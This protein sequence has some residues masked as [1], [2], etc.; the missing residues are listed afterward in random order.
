MDLRKLDALV[1]EHVMGLDVSCKEI[2][3]DNSTI[4]VKEPN[5]EPI[6]QPPEM[7][8]VYTYKTRKFHPESYDMVPNYST[9]ISNA[10]EVKERISKLKL[11]N[12]FI[13]HLHSFTARQADLQKNTDIWEKITPL[14]I[15]IAAL[16]AIDKDID[17]S[18]WDLEISKDKGSG[19]WYGDRE[20]EE[21]QTE[22]DGEDK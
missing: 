11:W 13:E 6:K 22:T 14:D 19:G 5:G 10:W 3:L 18:E 12:E 7:L 1:A 9:D 4:W 2:P 8:K 20:I 16:K 17:V 15:C 21:S